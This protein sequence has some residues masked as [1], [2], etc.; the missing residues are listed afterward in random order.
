M[1]KEFPLETLKAFI[2]D[3]VGPTEDPH[4]WVEVLMIF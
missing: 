4:V 2:A 1:I 3:L